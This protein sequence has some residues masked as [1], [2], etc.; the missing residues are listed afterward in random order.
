MLRSM[1]AGISGLRAHQT[2]LD[3]VSNNISNVNTTGYKSTRAT[4]QESLTQLLRGA[5]APN[6][7]TGGTNPMQLGLGTTVA[8]VDQ[9]F[10]QGATML[11]GRPTD[12]SISGDGFFLMDVNGERRYTR[13]GTF[14]IDAIGNLTNP[15]G[16]IVQGWTADET[17]EIDFDLPVGGLEIPAGTL[18]DPVATGEVLL[19]GN[20]PASAAV[21]DTVTNS[22]TIYDSLG[23]EQALTVQYEKAG[24]NAWT[25]TVTPPVGSVPAVLGP[26]GLT[27]D[28]DG[29]LTA[30][31]TGQISLTGLTFPGGS[32]PQDI[33]L[34][35]GGSP[36]LVQF[37][38]ATSAE[39]ISQDGSPL[40][41]M[42][43]LAVGNDGSITGQFSNGQTKVLGF[44]A[45]ATF[46]NPGGLVRVG[47]STWINSSN[48]GEAAIDRPGV[49]SAGSL[50]A[51]TL[52]MSNVDLAE[53]FTQLIIA[54]RGFQANSRTITTSDDVLQELV[55]LKR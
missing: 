19:G 10:A 31:A 9:N 54:Q 40:G 22:I 50:S 24:A 38:G 26:F 35:F 45:L 47:E 53:E 36:P 8:S 27:F 28:T 18:L 21:G 23:A 41:V 51:G 44:V 17:G 4:F 16:G 13:S 48:S 34:E 46:N 20:L 43:V 33:T 52:E 15:S 1:F 6:G 7:T 14:S 32:S 3:V 49:G 55:N 25:A 42:K 29:N 37:G 12:V 2:M 5:G 11:T 30:P 39:P